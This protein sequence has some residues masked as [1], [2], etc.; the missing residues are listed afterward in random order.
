VRPA[1]HVHRSR[2]QGEVVDVV[3]L[4]GLAVLLLGPQP[5]EDFDELLGADVALVV[6]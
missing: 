3:V 1:R 2:L 4:A 6:L 5:A